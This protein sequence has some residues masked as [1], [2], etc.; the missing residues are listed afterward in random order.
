[1]LAVICYGRFL[2]DADTDADGLPS[3]R[4]GSA[5]FCAW[6]CPGST[7]GALGTRF[8]NFSSRVYNLIFQ[9]REKHAI[10]AEIWVSVCSFWPN[11]ESRI[12]TTCN[13][14]PR[15]TTVAPSSRN[16]STA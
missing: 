1:M 3:T 5:D 12:L 6:I 10:W 15:H 14:M 9:H 2:V 11:L 4:R 16:D 13:L 7:V 8:P